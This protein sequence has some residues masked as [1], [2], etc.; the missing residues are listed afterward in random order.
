MSKYEIMKQKEF[1]CYGCGAFWEA[2]NG[3]ILNMNVGYVCAD[4]SSKHAVWGGDIRSLGYIRI[5]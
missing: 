2:Q 3:C 4:L 5:L 1:S